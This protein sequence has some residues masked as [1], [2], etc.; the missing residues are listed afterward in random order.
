MDNPARR[1]GPP[2]APAAEAP[3]G[4]PAAGASTR[5]RRYDRPMLYDYTSLSTE[6]VRRETDAGL[7]AADGLIAQVVDRTAR[8]AGARQGTFATTMAPLDQALERVQVA[9]GRGAFMARVHPDPDVRDAGQVAEERL[10][11][12]RVALPFRDD[13]C[14]AVRAYASTDEAA[15]LTGERRRLLE[16]WLRDLRRAGH[17]LSP[18]AR[19]ELERLHARLVELEVLFQRNVDEYHDGIEVTREELAGLPDSYV[20][21][22]P[23]GS[24]PGTYEVSLEYPSVFPFL[25][26]ADRRDLREQLEAKLYNRAAAVNRPIIEEALRIRKRIATLFGLRSWADY[27]LEI[28]MAANR[29]AVTRFYDGLVPPL[30]QK[31][32]REVANLAALLEADTGDPNLRSWDWR[33]YENQV[34]RREFGLDQNRIA[35]FLPLDAVVEGMLGLTGEV[36]GLTYRRVDPTHAWHPDVLLYEIHDS[37]NGELVAHFYADLFPREGKYG[38][39]AAFPLVAGH[40]RPDGTYEPP[41]S[42]I[43]ANFTRPSADQPSLLRHDEVVTL[44]H[45]FGHILHQSLTRAEFVRFSGTE[46]ELDFVEAPSQIMEHWAWDAEVLRRF[47]AHYRTGE[48]IPIDVVAELVRSRDLDVALR[49]LRQV[50]LGLIDLGFHDEAEERDLDAVNRRAWDVSGIPFHEGTFFPGAFAHLFGGYDAG[51]YGYLWSK[52]YGDDMFGRFR[53]AGVTSPEV[54]AAYRREIL[55]VGGSRDAAESLRAF[56]GR[57]PSNETFLR[58]LGIDSRTAEGPGAHD[59]GPSRAAEEE[60]GAPTGPDVGGV[61]PGM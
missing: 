36:F 43:V 54:G 22:L 50:S 13:L 2:H 6:T 28:K 39:A 23:P 24:A 32:R 27:A 25:D 53:E 19:A 9:Y 26:Q 20:E 52:V 47:A 42:A 31:A 10:A 30:Q 58:L 40:R 29:A 59:A 34:R 7:S 44:F 16:H 60:A 35:E 61:R 21:R 4:D 1:G 48:P 49:T 57:E 12:W 15:A 8:A 3:A 51:Y 56:L 17:D 37:G 5:A 33:Y 18:E 55:E 45:E 14:A 41:V 11:K 38:H 46:T